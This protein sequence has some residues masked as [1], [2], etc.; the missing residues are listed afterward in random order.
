MTDSPHICAAVI[1]GRPKFFVTF[2]YPYMNGMLHLGHAYTLLKCDFMARYYKSK[3]YDVLFPFGFHGTGMPIFSVA[4]KIEMDD[5]R[6]KD[7]LLR[8]LPEGTELDQ[9]K[10][11]EHWLEYFPAQAQR[12]LTDL[13][14]AVDWTRSFI[15]TEIN[16]YYDSFVRW[17]FNT[18]RRKGLITSGYRYAVYSIRDQQPCADHDRSEGEGINPLKFHIHKIGSVII[19]SLTERK[20]KYILVNGKSLFYQ[21]CIG[22]ISYVATEYLFLNLKYQLNCH[23]H[24]ELSVPID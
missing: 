7:N 9:F 1:C 4:K 3:G 24:A 14:I 13:N 17:Q 2:P 11:A 18:L 8:S 6:A 16:P 19:P 21:C 15:T 22:K 10:S 20:P 5:P 12:D 23:S